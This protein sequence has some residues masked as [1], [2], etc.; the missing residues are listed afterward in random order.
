MNEAELIS[1]LAD[2]DTKALE[3]IMKKYSGY[4][5]TVV[6]NFSRGALSEEDIDE[7]SVEVFY[8][9]W[10]LRKNIEIKIGLAA[11]LSA[12]ARNA[13]KNRFRSMK[14]PFEDISELEISS[15]FLVE[16]K[17]EL[18]M[19]T[20]CLNEGIKQLSEKDREIF[21]RFYLYGESSSQIARAM[22]ISEGS[23]RTNLHRTRAGLKE[24]MSERG[25]E[26]V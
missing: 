21:L 24:F 20:E 4:V 11:Y 10:S 13:V 6:R 25:Y 23:V 19:M 16:D 17:A 15:G 1:A 2:G 9:L 18:S 22:N 7:I 3:V 14:P 5:C 26:H 12:A 8:K